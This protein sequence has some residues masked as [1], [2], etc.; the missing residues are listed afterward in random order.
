[1]SASHFCIPRKET[2]QPPYLQNR[3]IMFCLQIPPL[4]HLWEI[5]ILLLSVCTVYLAAANI[6]SD[7]RNIS[8]IN[9]SQTHE[10]RN[11]DWGRGILSL[12]I[13]KLDFRYSVLCW[14]LS[15]HCK[16][17]LAVFPSPA[18]MSLIKLFLGGNNL[19]FPAQREF[20]QWHPGWGRENG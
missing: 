2:V 20:D 19:V 15:P 16:K 14:F 7:P 4:I 17:G 18:G 6:W 5:F 11:W 13:H 10:C 1:M 12:G 8:C 9:R 3:I